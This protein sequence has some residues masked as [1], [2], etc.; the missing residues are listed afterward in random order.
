M[1]R[2]HSEARYNTYARPYVITLRTMSAELRTNVREAATT[3][4]WTGGRA[5][6]PGDIQSRTFGV[7][8]S[9]G[10]LLW[11]GERVRGG[12]DDLV[13]ENCEIHPDQTQRWGIA[14]S[15]R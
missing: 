6:G 8:S 10:T 5:E 1:E 7:F 11:R 4:L 9:D 12:D 13:C 15:R 2:M 14:L 3:T